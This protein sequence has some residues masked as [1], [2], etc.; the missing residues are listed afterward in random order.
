MRHHRPCTPAFLVIGL[1]APAVT[2]A[3]H[4][5]SSYR[6]SDRRS[7]AALVGT[8][9]FFDRAWA[10]GASSTSDAALTLLA[11]DISGRADSSWH[12]CLLCPEPVSKAESKAKPRVSVK[13]LLFEG[14]VVQRYHSSRYRH[15]R[16]CDDQLDVDQIGGQIEGNIAINLN[17]NQNKKNSA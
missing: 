8:G 11:D 9:G 6:R 7:P 13:A 4:L 12:L 1:C 14:L 5:L 3:C 16:G 10:T 17:C 15:E 2:R